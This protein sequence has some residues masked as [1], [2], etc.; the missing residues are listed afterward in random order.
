MYLTIWVCGIFSEINNEHILKFSEFRLILNVIVLISAWKRLP[1][2][3]GYKG[4]R[5]P[6]TLPPPR[7]ATEPRRMRLPSTFSSEWKRIRSRRNK[8]GKE[9]VHVPRTIFVLPVDRNK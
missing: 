8:H 4:K 2:F 3:A 1:E 7:R 6:G 5:Y 9:V